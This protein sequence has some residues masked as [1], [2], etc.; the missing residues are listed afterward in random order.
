MT[1]GSSVGPRVEAI[2]VN[3]QEQ[4]QN[5]EGNFEER[6]SVSSKVSR[7]LSLK[8]ASEKEE[9]H[10]NSDLVQ[11]EVGSKVESNGTVTKKI[12]GNTES[13]GGSRNEMSKDYKEP[14]V[15]M[16][17][18][19]RVANNGMHLAYFPPQIVNGEAMVQLE[20]KEVQDEEDKWKCALIAYVVGE[21]PGYNAMNRYIM[22]NWSKVG[23][24]DDCSAIGVPLFANECTTKQTR[25]SYAR[26]LIEVNVTKPIP[27]QITVMDPNGRT[28][29]QEIV[30]EWKPQY[31]DKCQKI[32]HQC[33]S[34]TMEEQPKKRKPWKKVTQ[35]WQ[36]E[37][38]IQQQERKN[39]QRKMPVVDKN[40][41]DAQEEKQEIEQGKEQENN[42]TPELN[43]RP[44][45]GSK[46]LNFNLSNFPMLSA[47]PIINGFEILRNSKLAPL[48]VHTGGALKTC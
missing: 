14:W 23:K 4:A 2:E 33:Q 43:L 32:G 36:Y 45:N 11:L 9:V 18:N 34:V 24:P 27:Q 6:V 25:I 13:N 21:C 10:E 1:V 7:R 46:H 22:M 42:Q 40:S 8:S 47:I 41:N 30:M 17:K 3:E 15:N 20:G 37:G 48:P 38:P 12:D 35:T 31:C 29:M 44:H 26:M 5:E 39:D 16:F 19:N 28:F